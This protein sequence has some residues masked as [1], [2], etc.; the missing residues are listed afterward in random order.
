M[1]L[2]RLFSRD[3]SILDS[4]VAEARKL[5]YDS[6]K[7]KISIFVNSVY[8]VTWIESRNGVDLPLVIALRTGAMCLLDQSGL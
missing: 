4:F 3:R 6:K 2:A 7:D 1:D 5:Y 8:V